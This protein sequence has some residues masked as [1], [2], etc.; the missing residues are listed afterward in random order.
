MTPED[1]MIKIRCNPWAK[2]IVFAEQPANF[3]G[4]PS[5]LGKK[6]RINIIGNLTN[7][8]SYTFGN[9][10]RLNFMRRRRP[11]GAFV[12]KPDHFTSISDWFPCQE[13]FD[14]KNI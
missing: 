2:P 4:W 1:S 6:Y 12:V 13:L 9:L 5:I 10:P 8:N 7:I 3:G 11:A 14:V